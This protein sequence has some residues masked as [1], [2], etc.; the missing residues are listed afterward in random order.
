MI[1]KK[2]ALIGYGYW[3]PNIARIISELERLEFKYCIDLSEETLQK[4]KVRYPLVN[5]SKN[6]HEVLNDNEIDAVF[7]VTPTKTHYAIIKDCLLA[8]KHVFVEKPLTY[9][10]HQAEELIKI[11]RE[12]NL[13]LMVGHVFLFNPAVKKIKEY[14]NNGEIGNIRYFNFQRR[15]LG[16]IRQDINVMWDLLPHDISMLLYFLDNQKPTSIQASGSVFLQPGIHD[17]VFINVKFS[18]EV[19]AN[20]VLSWLDP[21]KIRDIT[22]VG[23]NKMIFFDDVM[24]SEKV[25]VFDRNVDILKKTQDSFENWIINLKSGDVYIPQI[26]NKEPLKEEVIHFIECINN[27]KQPK[28]GGINGLNVVRVIEAAQRSLDNNSKLINFKASYIN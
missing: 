9:S 14:I 15:N 16:P 25:K 13:V 28:T 1:N 12:K 11:A 22:I 7:I 17:V 6:Y 2:V 26:E 10:V 18:N 8:G 3:G 27:N 4:A 21:I 24:P 20:F 5:I 19:I 23:D